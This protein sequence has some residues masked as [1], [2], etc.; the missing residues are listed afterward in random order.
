MRKSGTDQTNAGS[1]NLRF[2]ASSADVRAP[3]TRLI[4]L[5]TFTKPDS[6]GSEFKCRDDVAALISMLDSAVCPVKTM[7]LEGEQLRWGHQ[8]Q[9]SSILIMACDGPGYLHIRFPKFPQIVRRHYRRCAISLATFILKCTPLSES[10]ESFN[11]LMVP[12]VLDS[13]SSCPS[14]GLSKAIVFKIYFSWKCLIR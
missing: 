6:R 8:F 5:N 3:S 9:K 7:L 2:Q 11:K 10:S 1:T 12:S 14:T 4:I 13:R